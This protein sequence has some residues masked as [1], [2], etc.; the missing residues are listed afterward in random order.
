M[1]LG[2]GIRYEDIAL[3]KTGNDLVLE[4]GSNDQITFKDW[5]ASTGNHSVAKLQTITQAMNYYS[6]ASTDTLKNKKIET[7]DFGALVAKYDQARA[8]NTTEALGGDIA[9]R[10]G[11]NG[12]LAGM[13]LLLAQSTID[14][15]TLGVAAQTL[16]AGALTN[17]GAVRLS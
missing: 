4:V 6:A 14:N 2:G 5:C 10:F 16:S 9:Y 17:D 7:F 15:P 8:G 1:S 12:D 11:K 3:S 13:N